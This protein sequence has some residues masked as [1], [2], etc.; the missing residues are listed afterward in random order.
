MSVEYVRRR[1]YMLG[2]H[3]LNISRFLVNDL[4]CSFG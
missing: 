2:A 1:H 4:D 3:I